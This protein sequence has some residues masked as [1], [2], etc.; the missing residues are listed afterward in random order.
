MDTIST[1]VLNESIKTGVYYLGHASILIKINGR[2]ILM[3]PIVC[4]VP[5]SGS[6][7]F[8][9]PQKI[10]EVLYEVDAVVVSHIHQDH[11]DPEF[12]SK[13][14]EGCKVIVIGGRPSFEENLLSRQFKRL[15][16]LEAGV[17]HEIFPGVRIFGMLHEA[18][19]IDASALVYSDS[20]SVYHGN[21]NYCSMDVLEEFQKVVPEVDVACLPYAYIHWYPFLLVEELQTEERK[22]ETEN[23]VFQ[24]M[25]HLVDSARLLRAKIVI[26]FGANLV[27]NN[28]DAESVINLAVK[29]PLELFEVI[30][31]QFPDVKSVVKP[32]IAG[33]TV[34]SNGNQLLVDQALIET[35]KE[36][37]QRMS[38]HLSNLIDSTK[39]TKRKIKPASV[40]IEELSHRVISK[41]SSLDFNIWVR[42]NTEGHPN[43]VL[44]NPSKKLVEFRS[45]LDSSSSYYL[46]I[47]EAHCSLAWLSGESLEEII[48][49]RGFSLMR[50]PD[51]YRPDALKFVNTVL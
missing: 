49:M 26:P 3:D 27:L 14:N 23:L 21:D 2:T 10:D 8:F 29:T 42:L 32:L 47:L 36:F 48:G 41:D 24:Y 33:D 19:G 22:V 40:F 44:I 46:F 18:N 25:K 31:E 13:L 7:V 39:K 17:S 43:F 11:Y 15:E 30:T 50:H 9:P 51:E 28:G 5:Y 6:W 35:A 34:V 1:F 38:E 4:S 45:E 12:L 20:F 16:I 37:R